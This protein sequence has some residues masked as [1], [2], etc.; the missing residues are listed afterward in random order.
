MFALT[1]LEICTTASAPPSC[2][3]LLASPIRSTAIYDG[4]PSTSVMRSGVR[5]TFIR[6]GPIVGL[7]IVWPDCKPRLKRRTEGWQQRNCPNAI[8]LLATTWP[9]LLGWVAGEVRAKAPRL[10][11][12]ASLSQHVN[13]ALPPAD[14]TLSAPSSRPNRPPIRHWNA[15]IWQRSGKVELA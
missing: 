2:S 5:P 10:H 1:D 4:P 8:R 15:A 11:L 13:E 7:L 14:D 3:A 6:S 12:R 9:W